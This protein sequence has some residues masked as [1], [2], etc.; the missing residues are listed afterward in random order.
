MNDRWNPYCHDCDR[1]L[2]PSWDEFLLCASA[3][4]AVT[5]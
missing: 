2:G 3:G 1:N 5:R 4:H